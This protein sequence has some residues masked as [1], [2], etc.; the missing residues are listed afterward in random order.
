MNEIKEARLKANLTQSAM[1]KLLNIPQR[2]IERWETDNVKPPDWTKALILEKLE[3]IGE[4]MQEQKLYEAHVLGFIYGYFQAVFEQTHS[5]ESI[6]SDIHTLTDTQPIKAVLKLNKFAVQQGKEIDNDLLT[7]LFGQIEF[8]SD[9]H[10]IDEK[11][12]FPEI[13]EPEQVRFTLGMFQGQNYFNN[14]I[15]NRLKAIKSNY[16]DYI[17]QN[18]F[19]DTEAIKALTHYNSLKNFPVDRLA[20]IADYLNCS[21]DYLLG[22][23]K[24]PK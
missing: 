7:V 4:L 3:R 15:A 20:Q 10:L 5:W 16:F 18:E 6:P 9:Y 13:T 11:T 2:N 23:E 8:L 14:R 21:V 12:K 1:A 19:T 22:N 24:T 17:S